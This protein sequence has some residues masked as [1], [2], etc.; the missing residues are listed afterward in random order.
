M[1]EKFRGEYRWLSNFAECERPIFLEGDSN[2]Y[3]TVEHAYQAAKTFYADYRLKIKNG[4]AVHAK[5]FFKN[6]KQWVRPDWNQV[7]LGIMEHCL[8][9][10][11]APGTSLLKKLLETGNEEIV[12]GNTWGDVFWGQ[13]PIGKGQNHLGKLLMKLRL[14]A[15]QG[16][17]E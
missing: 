13:C 5:R 9:Q 17:T 2:E 1:I 14:E 6:L 3:P 12:E 8:R 10:K 15:K 16:E 4:D 7:K 11:F